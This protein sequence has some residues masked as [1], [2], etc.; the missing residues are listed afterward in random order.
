MNLLKQQADVI[1][2]H[3]NADVRD[4]EKGEAGHIKCKGFSGGQAYD[5]SSD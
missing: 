3:E 1:L 4:V 5:H 2:D